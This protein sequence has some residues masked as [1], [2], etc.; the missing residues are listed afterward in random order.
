MNCNSK[1]PEL[2]LYIV[3][4][5]CGVSFCL[6]ILV[7]L[8]LTFKNVLENYTSKIIICMSIN[9]ALCS[10]SL[11]LFEVFV[12]I[13]N[14]CAFLYIV[15]VSF[16]SNFIWALC[17]AITLREAI[18][19]KSNNY[20]KYFKFWFLIAYPVLLILFALPFATNS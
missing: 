16:M 18:I 1:I 13:I 20:I 11:I 15:F 17:I 19:K 3:I 7:V 9:D 14:N 12:Q 10:S 6:S 5:F 8:V 2:D 4:A